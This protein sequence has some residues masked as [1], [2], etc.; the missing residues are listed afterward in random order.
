MQIKTGYHFAP[1]RVA[2][3]KK[4]VQVLYKDVEKSEP[5]YIAIKFKMVVLLWKTVW[6]FFK[7]LNIE[8]TI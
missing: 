3:I 7:E 2:I 1:I 5:P 4:T 6:Q 8:L